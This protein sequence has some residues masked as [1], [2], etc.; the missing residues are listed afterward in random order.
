MSSH[1]LS[2]HVEEPVREA[3]K[4]PEILAPKTPLHRK[5]W[6]WGVLL[7]VLIL[8]GL[9][10]YYAQRSNPAVRLA[11]TPGVRSAVVH[12]GTLQRTIRV[13]GSTEAKHGVVLRA[14]YLR[15]SRGRGGSRDFQLELT[16]LADPGTRVKEGD[17]VAVFDNVNMRNRLD[18]VKADRVDLQGR[19]KKLAADELAAYTTHQQKIRVARANV[20]I[21]RLDL[22]TAPIRSAIQARQFAL[23]L[24]EAQATY[25]S[26]SEQSKYYDASHDADLRSMQLQLDMTSLEEGRAQANLDRLTVRAPIDGLVVAQEIYRNGNPGQVRNGD[27]LRSGQPFLGIVDVRSMAVEA[28]IN[29]ADVTE[30]RI[31]APVQVGFDAYPRLKL[32]GIV[33]SIGA[34][35]KTNGWRAD[36][37]AEVPLTIDIEHTDEKVIPSLSVSGDIVLATEEDAEIVPREAIFHDP[38]DDRPYAF[39]ETPSGWEKRDVEV[40]LEN[41]VAVG[42][43]SGIKEGERVALE[44]PTEWIDTGSE[45]GTS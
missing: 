15:G 2:L 13:T 3:P 11:A 1:R 21:A 22:K 33:R 28:T 9:A 25:K 6:S 26:L 19:Y 8:G 44:Q 45:A 10:F 40:G 7:A 30:L 14:P 12:S 20:D 36:Y 32:P 41:N 43:R 31:G 5:P 18:D 38:G 37:V 17:I 4:K 29:Q 42:V 35:A 39:V 24:E 23:S 34:I 27:E 16:K